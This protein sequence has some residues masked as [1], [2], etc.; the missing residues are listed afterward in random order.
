MNIMFAV[1]A[2]IVLLMGT[3][4]A[5]FSQVKLFKDILSGV[6]FDEMKTDPRFKDCSESGISMLCE[7]GHEFLNTS[8]TL[9]VVFQGGYS[10]KVVFFSE[11]AALFQNAISVFASG[12]YAV[13]AIE[14]R[15][16]A[17]DLVQEISANGEDAALALFAEMETKG[18][19]TGYVSYLFMEADPVQMRQSASLV[20]L[21]MKLPSGKRLVGV[22]LEETLGLSVSSTIVFDLNAT[23][24]VAL[25][26][27]IKDAIDRDF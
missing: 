18:L 1:S 9:G 19:T 23:D 12:D 27:R 8:G 11:S 14:N 26:A 22:T 10:F 15:D 6:P 17:V 20:D 21:S 13:A 3:A 24:Q 2:A 4:T 7:E 5:G 16:R 25:F